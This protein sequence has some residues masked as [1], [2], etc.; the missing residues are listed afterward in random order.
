MK[1]FP[2]IDLGRCN[3]CQGCIEVAPAVF[4]YNS[5]TGL[6]EVADLNNY[7]EDL[8][9]EAIKN[10]PEDCIAWEYVD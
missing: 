5:A 9:E 2:V 8:V 7:P 10:C 1:R 6:M 3:D 4:R